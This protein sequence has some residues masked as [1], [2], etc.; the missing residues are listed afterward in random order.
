MAKFATASG[1]PGA[2]KITGGGGTPGEAITV[3]ISQNGTVVK[4]KSGN[5]D[6]NGQGSFT[7]QP[8]APGTYDVTITTADGT[9]YDFPNTVVN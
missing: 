8:F 7:F 6:D 5:L 2:I 9:V 4:S 3:V 1:G